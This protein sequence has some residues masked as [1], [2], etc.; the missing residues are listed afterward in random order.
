[1]SRA[2]KVCVAAAAALA[3]GAIVMSA[4]SSFGRESFGAT[5]REAGRPHPYA[6]TTTALAAARAVPGAV[7]VRYVE[8]GDESVAPHAGSGFSFKCPKAAPH[9][10]AGYGGPSQPAGEGKVVL[11]DA[12]PFKKGRS[13]S[14]GVTNLSDQPQSFFVGIV[15]VG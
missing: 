13:L 8:S 4:S 12:F 14:V 3:L 7:K 1:M 15:C 6:S 11:S 10:V 5:S 2:N 9:A